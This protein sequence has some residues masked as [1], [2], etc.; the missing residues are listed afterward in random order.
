M[1]KNRSKPILK[2]V[3]QNFEPFLANLALVSKN[4]VF[5]KF[6]FGYLT[7]SKGY[8]GVVTEKIQEC[9]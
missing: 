4:F 2:Y 5:I 9:E 8:A 6:D 1:E 3:F 7:S